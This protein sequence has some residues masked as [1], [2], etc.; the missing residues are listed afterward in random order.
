L[1]VKLTAD[2]DLGK[3]RRIRGVAQDEVVAS[4]RRFFH[5]LCRIPKPELATS[6]SEL[7]GTGGEMLAAGFYHHFIDLDHV[8]LLNRRILENLP[9]RTAIAATDYQHLPW[10][11]GELRSWQMRYGLVIEKLVSLRCHDDSIQH[12]QPSPVAG[13]VYFD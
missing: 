6:V 9:H 8:H 5:K 12:Q 4:V 13:I 7:P 1:T 10:R 11:R 2:E 3:S